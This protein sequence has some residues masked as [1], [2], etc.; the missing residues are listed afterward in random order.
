[1]NINSKHIIIIVGIFMLVSTTFVV[2]KVLSNK[3]IESYE[4][5][6]VNEYTF[7]ESLGFTLP[8]TNDPCSGTYWENLLTLVSDRLPNMNITN[9]QYEDL[10]TLTVRV[11]EDYIMTPG[12]GRLSRIV[13][14]LERLTVADFKS[15]VVE[16]VK[17]KYFNDL[18]NIWIGMEKRLCDLPTRRRSKPPK[19]LILRIQH[20]KNGRVLK[21]NTY[22]KK[23]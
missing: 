21:K 8:Q 22:N 18:V 11:A 19:D 1:M 7:L 14:A 5:T 2:C 12:T 23:D 4:N 13:S 9:E 10:Y 3:P 20:L 15:K 16:H 6:G 17:R